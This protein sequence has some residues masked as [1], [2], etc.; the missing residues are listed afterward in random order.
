MP[1]RQEYPRRKMRLR[2]LVCV[3]LL[4]FDDSLT[5]A[6]HVRSL[7]KYKNDTVSSC[8]TR[9]S[10]LASVCSMLTLSCLK[11]KTFLHPKNATRMCQCL[12][13]D[14]LDDVRV[15]SNRWSFKAQ[16]PAPTRNS[17]SSAHLR[18]GFTTTHRR[19]NCWRKHRGSW[20][21]RTT[22]S[23]RS[24]K[25]YDTDRERSSAGTWMRFLQRKR[26]LLKAGSG[27]PLSW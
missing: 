7:A 3:H 18:H 22:V 6:L 16:L 1:S 20:V 15:V 21:L 4:C 10:S 5:A 24:R 11:S 25:R 23:G 8:S 9:S 14:D 12:Q 26:V 2:L 19:L 17:N 27:L 13:R